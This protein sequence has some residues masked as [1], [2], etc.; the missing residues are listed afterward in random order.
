MLKRI[1]IIVFLTANTALFAQTILTIEG[2]SVNNTESGTWAGVNIPRSNPTTFT[3]RNNSITSI[4]SNGYL[5]QAGDEIQNSQS[6]NLDGM[7]ISGNKFTWNGTDASSITH[8]VFTG[9]N[10]NSVVKYNYLDIVP[11]GIIFKSGTDDGKNMT[12][13]SGG[14][15]YN[16]VKDGKYAVRGKGING[17]CVYNNTFYCGN[18]FG[19]YP[20]YITTNMDKDIPAASTGWGIFNN[21]FYIVNEGIP[22]VELETTGCRSGFECDYNLYYCEESSNHEPVFKIGEFTY[23]W[24]QWRALGYDS[25]SVVVNPDFIDFTNF[26]PSERLNYGTNLGSTWQTGLSTTATWSVGSTPSTTDQNGTWQVGARVFAADKE[27]Q[28]V[29]I[30]PNPAFNHI[31]ISIIEPAEVL[32]YISIINLSNKVVFHE[33]L[34]P[35]ARESGLSINLLP[36]VYIVQLGLNNRPHFSE[37]MVVT[38]QY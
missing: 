12:F 25:H 22:C 13:T 18:G 23:T 17:I 6:N 34:N 36:G 10:I 29:K 33:Q 14:C 4:N 32:D 21:I 9:Y 5:L 15:A 3:Y 38:K 26:V 19:W 35:D 27:D 37:K 30:Y 28:I 16:I 2:T 24:S 11:Y 7:I 20:I 31:Y 8:A 1:S